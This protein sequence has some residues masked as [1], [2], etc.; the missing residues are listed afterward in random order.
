M[1][2]NSE[3][4]YKFSRRATAANCAF[5]QPASSSTS[6]SDG[7]RDGDVTMVLIVDLSKKN[8]LDSL[9]IMWITGGSRQR[10]GI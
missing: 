5:D 7:M 6:E 3:S 4:Q 2:R 8:R 9:R 10:S 1:C